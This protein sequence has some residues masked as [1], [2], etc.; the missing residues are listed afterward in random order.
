MKILGIETSCDDTSIAVYDDNFGLLFC[1]TKSQS[2]I[3]SKYGGVVP[4]IASR[5]HFKNVFF[6]LNK[7]IKN[8]KIVKEE[9]NA[10]S[11]TVGPGLPGSLLVGATVAN[12]LSYLWKI[13]IIFVNHMEAHLFS[14]MLDFKYFIKPKFPFLSLLVSGGHTQIVLAKSF[15]KYTILGNCLDDSAG[16]VIDK[17]SN[18]IGIKYPGGKKMSKL[19]K[20]G[21]SGVFSFPRPMINSNDLN[22]SFSGLK[23][24]VTKVVLNSNI[25]NYQVKCN[26]AR[27]LQNSI[28]SVLVKKCFKALKIMQ[29]NKLVVSG[30]VSANI[31]LRKRIID[32]SKK[33][34]NCSVYFTKKNFCT[35]NGA[36]VA[37]LGMLYFKHNFYSSSKIFFSPKLSIVKN[38]YFDKC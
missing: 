10:I 3:H 4:E 30:G 15:G 33:I 7:L 17:I 19:A 38:I 35:D 2:K 13:P 14:Y 1:C 16:E 6:L 25:K 9:I 31:F 24:H 32:M 22:F 8:K 23:T 21:K 20:H 11:Y 36:M 29:L 5:L 27:E 18:M 26:I 34:K 12:S 28:V 37:Y